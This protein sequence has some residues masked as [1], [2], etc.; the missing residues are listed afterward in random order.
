M[1]Q[2]KRGQGVSVRICGK[3]N[4]LYDSTDAPCHICKLEIDIT[5]LEAKLAVAVE[6]LEKIAGQ[7]YRGNRSSESVAAYKALAKIKE[8]E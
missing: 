3:H 7:D 2:T 8:M 4:Q 5:S 1:A 6:A